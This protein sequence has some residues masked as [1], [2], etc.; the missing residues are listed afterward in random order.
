MPVKGI[1]ETRIRIRSKLDEISK[2]TTQKAI[3]AI[4]REGQAAGATMVPIDTGFLIN[5]SFGP[6]MLDDSLGRVG[7]TAEYALW[8]HEAPG[9]LKGQ[10]R[11][12]FGMT[13]N[14]S[15]FGPQKPRAFGGGSGRG[16]YWDPAGEP[17]FLAKGF[18]SVVPHVPRILKEIYGK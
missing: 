3:F 4:L 11:K 7:Y 9:T 6:V 15:D 1:K 18:S 14:H 17:K 12:D 8:V 13:S 2:D 10:P 5:S 16:R